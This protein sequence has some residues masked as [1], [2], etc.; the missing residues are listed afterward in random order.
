MIN[1]DQDTLSIT[2]SYVVHITNVSSDLVA[3]SAV[4]VASPHQIF[5]NMISFKRS[6]GIDYILYS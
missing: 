1:R 6:V 5:W 4:D 2:M 3:G